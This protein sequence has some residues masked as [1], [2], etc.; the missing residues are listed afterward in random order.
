MI[1]KKINFVIALFTFSFVAVHALE[2]KVSPNVGYRRDKIGSRL[3]IEESDSSMSSD[4]TYGYRSLNLGQIG[5]EGE[6]WLNSH[7]YIKGEG[8]IGSLISGK[9]WDS[10]KRTKV[11]QGD[12][13]D[14]DLILGCLVDVSN[15]VR[16]GPE[17]GWSY[18]HLGLKL[19]DLDNKS[20]RATHNL[21][22]EGPWLGLAAQCEYLDWKIAT[23]YQYHWASFKSKFKVKD[24]MRHTFEND[25]GEGNVFYVNVHR[26]IS[27]CIDVGFEVSYRSFNARE[28]FAVESEDPVRSARI[29]LSDKWQSLGL[30]ASLGYRF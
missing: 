17:V 13:R 25:D 8:S 26:L 21:S 4:S 27:E 19:K 1:N 6:V 18:N 29:A 9:V 20:P 12:S 24:E 14:L 7:V 23:G 16:V 5:L 28:V 3:K 2:W 11:C 30:C 22:W 15:C 10:S